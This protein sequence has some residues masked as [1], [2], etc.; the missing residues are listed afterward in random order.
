[1]LIFIFQDPDAVLKVKPMGTEHQL[2]GS[3]DGYIAQFPAYHRQ[4]QLFS[5]CHPLSSRKRNFD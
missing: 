3:N 5:E 2:I 1:M 4:R